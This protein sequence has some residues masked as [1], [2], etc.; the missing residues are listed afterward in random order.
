MEPLV[1]AANEAEMRTALAAG[2]RVIGVNNRN[3]H[4]FEVDMSTTGRCA[5][6]IPA[7]SGVLLLALSGVASRA[8]V[9]GFADVGAAGVLVGESLMRAP[10]PAGLVR[11]LLA[12]PAP[13][14]MCKVC[15]VRDATSAL[16]AAA[17]GADLIG[18]I[19]APSKRRVSVAQA[20]DIVRAVRQAHPRPAGWA[21]GRFPTRA[22]ADGGENQPRE[23]RQWLETWSALLR[24]AAAQA[25]PLMVGVFVD[26]PA[27]EMN[28][29]AE[30][31]GLDLI[32]LH[33]HS[34]GWDVASQLCRPAIRVVHME[35]HMSADQVCGQVKA[36]PPAAVL[37]DSKGGGTGLTFDWRIG[38]EV[39][40]RT[41]FILA[42]GLTPDNVAAAVRQVRPWCVD[43]SS[44]VE[45]D[46]HKDHDKI[47]AYVR[48]AKEE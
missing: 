28:S 38:A 13:P 12:L 10:S 14:A 30:A 19:L 17:A 25:G 29:A 4:T 2:A 7:N 20:A 39:Q 40:Q 8:D 46:G 34:E 15:G 18:L 43:V 36:G 26:A 11:E 32:Q 21:V 44:G 6:L 3:L 48:N 45:T 37:L 33:G 42:G 22:A 5:A 41:P 35:P 16:A 9:T 47:R 23:M 27:D 24:R 31:A 1:E